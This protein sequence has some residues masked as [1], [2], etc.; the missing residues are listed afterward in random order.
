VDRQIK[1]RGHR[2]EPVE[3]EAALARYP[4]VVQAHA[5]VW[6]AGSGSELVAWFVSHQPTDSSELRAFLWDILPHY[7]VPSHF[8]PVEQFPLTRSG[9]IDASAL[10][11]PALQHNGASPLVPPRTHLERRLA[12]IWEEVL[13]RR[14]IGIHENFFDMGGHSLTAAH[15]V[16]RIYQDLELNVAVRDVYDSASIAKLADLL[17]ARR[18]SAWHSIPR[19]PI[20]ETFPLSHAQRGVWIA[21]ELN[22]EHFWNRTSAVLIEGDLDIAAL[23]SAFD[24]L[25]ARH[26]SLRS[27]VRF[28]GTEPM[29]HVAAG[30]ELRIVKRD[31]SSTPDPHAAART[32]IQDERG[33]AI[34]IGRAPLCRAQLLHLN[35]QTRVLVLTIHHLICDGWSIQIL[36]QELVHLY[37]TFA[38]GQA[39]ALPPIRLQYRD[40]STWH[41]A[42]LASPEAEPLRDYWQSRLARL[43][44]RA[45]LPYDRARK[46]AAVRNSGW[47]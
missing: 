12:S 2:I 38:T 31:L 8:I 19:A 3:V 39:P 34:D 37:Q 9:K 13:K 1:I 42:L 30:A 45:T 25:L 41:N 14:P 43:G 32:L 18:Q 26:E 4:N 27:S 16:A 23:Q 36:S 6:D 28:A 7:M 44:S 46:P 35:A 20:A 17:A 29:Q 47:W 11:A 33:T 40:F 24:H 15:L 22:P 10:P 5:G 21:G